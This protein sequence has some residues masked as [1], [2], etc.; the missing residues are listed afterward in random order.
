MEILEDDE[1]PNWLK[2]GKV[3]EENLHKN[4]PK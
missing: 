4:I 1:I 3:Y 2:K